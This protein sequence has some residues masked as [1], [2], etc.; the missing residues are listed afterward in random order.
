M[1]K[2]RPEKNASISN[3]QIKLGENAPIIIKKDQRKASHNIY[4]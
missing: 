2:K 1:I 3:N 4:N